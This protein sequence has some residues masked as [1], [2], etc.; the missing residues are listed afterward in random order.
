MREQYFKC[1]FVVKQEVKTHKGDE[2]MN[3]LNGKTAIVT[4]AS[5]GIGRSIALRL[6]QEGAL[7]VVHYAK[8]KVAAEEVVSEITEN[9]GTSFAIGAEFHSSSGVNKLIEQMDI[10]LTEKTGDNRFDIL[11]NNAGIGHIATLEELTEDSFDNLININVKAPL[12][13]TQQ[14]LPRL[15]D[16]GRIINISSYVTRVAFPIVFGYGMT[17]GAM[18]TLTLTLAKQLGSRQ[19]TVNA[20]LP[21]ITNT[22]M[23]ASTLQDPEGKKF[24]ASLSAFNRVGQPK[25]ISDIAAFLASSDS[26]WITGQLIDASGGANL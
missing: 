16:G 24:V 17:K 2:D 25:D 12:F 21:G 10:L 6:A 3:K 23:N 15:K 1:P 22:D 4:G 11:V 8:N 13:L 5:R 20:I 19:I 14:A 18:N 9:G 26:R 7:V